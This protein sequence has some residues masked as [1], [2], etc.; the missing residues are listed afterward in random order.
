MFIKGQDVKLA[1]INGKGKNR[2]RENGDV[3]T[4]A[5]VEKDSIMVES[6]VNSDCARWV[7][8]HNDPVM[9]IIQG[10]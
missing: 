4:V 3:W 8:L 10:E 9:K 6:K 1:G 7:M 2:I 5:I